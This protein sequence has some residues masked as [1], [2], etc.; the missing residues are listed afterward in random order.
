[1]KDKKIQKDTCGHRHGLQLEVKP[2]TMVVWFSQTL[3]RHKV[4][5]TLSLIMVRILQNK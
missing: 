1:M 5:G 3:F 4:G 2:G